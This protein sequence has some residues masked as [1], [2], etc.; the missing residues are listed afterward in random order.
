MRLARPLLFVILLP[1]LAP[2]AIGAQQVRVIPD[3]VSCP[4]CQVKLEHVLTLGE[5]E[6][7]GRVMRPHAIV[8]DSKGNYLVAHGDGSGGAKQ[9]WVFDPDG[10]F[11]RALGGEGEGPGEFR[12][13]GRIEVLPGDTLVVYD[14][15]LRRRTTL[16]SD[17]VV[18]ETQPYETGRF[19]NSVLLP[20]GRMVINEHQR[21]PNRVGYPLHLVNQS[22]RIVRSF[23]SMNPEYRPR[24][25]IKYNRLLSP[26]SGGGSV[27][28]IG[29]GDYL[30][31]LWD[32]LGVRKTAFQR[33]TEWFVPFVADGGITPDGPPP[34]TWI[35]LMKPYGPGRLLVLGTA[36]REEWREVAAENPDLSTNPTAL[37]KL[38]DWIFEL[39]DLDRG[40]IVLSQTFQ[41]IEFASFLGDDQV[42]S[43]RED[44]TGY[45]YLDIWRIV[46]VK[47]APQVPSSKWRG[48]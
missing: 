47:P 21:S 25:P 6:G 26:G 24:Q 48:L 13:I 40:E 2:V 42:V 22:G 8:Q 15:I 17:F 39:L 29:R 1:L 18:V 7:P 16:T 44:E 43:Y 19:F 10:A 5:P 23:G 35:R 36:P 28:S 33:E 37:L 46:V 3:E 4:T 20:D 45:P 14:R 9:I 31:E 38:Y 41:D 30:I 32:T 27:W 34:A 11:I 12:G